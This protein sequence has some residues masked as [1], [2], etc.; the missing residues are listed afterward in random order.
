MT[1]KL[2]VVG[3]SY[4]DNV[5]EK[6]TYGKLLSDKL[7]YEYLH[8]ALGL[9]SNYRMWRKVTNALIDGSLTANDLLIVQYTTIERQEFWSDHNRSDAPNHSDVS[10]CYE[11]GGSIIK[12]KIDSYSYQKNK[13]EQDFLEMYQ[14]HFVNIDFEREKFIYNN[15]LFQNALANLNINTIFIHN[16]YNSNF[17]VIDKYKQ[18]EFYEPEILRTNPDFL[19]HPTLD[20]YH[21]SMSGHEYL[22]NSLYNHITN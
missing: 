15:F 12:F 17:A 4:S 2:F 7:G 16:R 8:N 3:C 22:A 14:S 21:L 20:P 5:E 6:F 18:L 1:Q 13:T 11:K 10:E 9:G 19:F